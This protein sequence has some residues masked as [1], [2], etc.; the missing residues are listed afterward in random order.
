[1]SKKIE[2]QSFIK[3]RK[4]K[5]RKEFPSIIDFINFIVSLTSFIANI[6]PYVGIA[7]SLYESI[8]LYDYATDFLHQIIKL[9]PNFLDHVKQSRQVLNKVI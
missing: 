9:I 1:M 7:K 8:F 2:Q 4:K 5:E 3:M 6:N